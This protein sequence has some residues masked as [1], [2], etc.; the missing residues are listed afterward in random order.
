M[1]ELVRR[2]LFLLLRG[3]R[4]IVDNVDLILDHDARRVPQVVRLVL[5]LIALA[6]RYRVFHGARGVLRNLTLDRLS[7][8]LNKPRLLLLLPVQKRLD[9]N[10]VI[11]WLLDVLLAGASC[12]GNRFAGQLLRTCPLFVGDSLLVY[13]VGVRVLVGLE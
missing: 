3:V 5:R 12:L 11:D 6:A 9:L 2:F 13:R 7:C 10:Q 1:V 4:G 8:A